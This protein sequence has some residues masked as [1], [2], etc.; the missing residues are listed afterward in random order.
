MQH[1][2]LESNTFPPGPAVR[3]SNPHSSE[4][5][6]EYLLLKPIL[7]GDFPL[8]ILPIILVLKPKNNLS[9]FPS[10]KQPVHH[11]MIIR[12]SIYQGEA[13]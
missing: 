8:S 13:R 9:S 1:L 6:E 2:P 7:P 4:G 11:L 12:D 5:R 10:T 3:V